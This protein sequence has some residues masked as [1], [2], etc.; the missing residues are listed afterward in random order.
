MFIKELKF[1]L[2]KSIDPREENLLHS[3]GF[4]GAKAQLRLRRTRALKMNL[5]FF[6][7]LIPPQRFGGGMGVQRDVGG[8]PGRL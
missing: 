7:A 1:R 4:Q 5:R 3:P 6:K 2:R 8:N